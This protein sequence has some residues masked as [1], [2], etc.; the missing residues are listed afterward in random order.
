MGRNKINFNTGYLAKQADG[1]VAVSCNETMVLATA[2]AAKDITEGQDFFPLTVDYR[3][4]FYSAGKIPGGF[5]KREG[6]ATDRE[7]LVSRLIDR[8]MRPLFPEDFV[9]EVQILINVLSADPQTQ[10]DVIAIN[11]SSAAL[12]I[13]GIPFAAPF[14][15]VRVARI[16]GNFMVNPSFEEVELSDIDLVVAGTMKAV[17]MI[18]GSSKNVSE[19]DMIDAVV[20]AHESIKKICAM[21]EEMKN[22]CAKPLMKY[23]PKPVDHELIKTVREK[24]Y[25]EVDALINQK[26]KKQREGAF[27]AIFEKAALELTGRF[28]DTIGQLRQILDDID[29]EIVRKRIIEKKERAD[30]RDLKTVRPIDIMIG[31]LPRAHGSAV[32]TRGQTQSLGVVT[33]G[34]A[35]DSQRLDALEGE[36]YSR[37]MLHYNFPPFSV[38]EIKRLGGVGRR[39]IGHGMLAQRS[40]EYVLPAEAD[41]PYT[42]RIVSDI[43]ESNGSSSMAT[44]CSASLA[45]FNAGVPV[46]SAVAGVAMGLVMEGDKYAVLSDILGLEDHLGD[47]DFKVAG[48]TTGI[49]GFQMDIKVQGITPEIMR[50]ALYQAKENRLFILQKMNEILP[51]PEAN[52]SKYAPK[53]IMITVEKDKI[54]MIIGPGGKVI[55]AITESS[56]CEINID[57]R[58]IVTIAG[59]DMDA[60]NRAASQIEAIAEDV[61]VGKIYTG[62]VKK[63]TEF[64]AF[65]E[66][67]PGKEGLVH[68]SKLDFKRVNN[69]TDVVNEG[70]SVT[71]KVIGVDKFGRIDLSRKDALERE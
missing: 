14:G 66:I 2:V 26:D 30:G 65:V 6:R 4:K 38:G 48:T 55:K 60:I 32:F 36:S 29:G 40:L 21:Q 19:D 13:S 28:P 7:V 20:F 62:I 64:G 43:L 41:F 15:A 16:D 71:V 39:E 63:V 42:I 47:M 24:Y 52:L 45:L 9:N 49:T 17:T 25:S 37:F 67:V 11:A 1:A 22:A 31:I 34:T 51:Q 68:I 23:K 57:D 54:G 3:E 50:E 8:P 44:I 5:L 56:G 12:I 59:T 10:P 61:K 33:L 53:I 69:V 27:T 58:G 70:D 46:K 35:D 18:E